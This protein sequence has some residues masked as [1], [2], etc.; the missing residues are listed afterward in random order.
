MAYGTILTV[1]SATKQLKQYNESYN[2][3]NVWNDLLSQNANSALAAE[4]ELLKSY[5]TA[6]ADAYVSY[7]KNQNAIINS[8]AVGQGRT[9]LLQ[10]NELALQDAYNSYMNSLQEGTASIQE[11][12]SQ[13]NQAVENAFAA[14]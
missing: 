2:R 11:S 13:S 3:Q 5:N 8:G 12:Y 7:L 6:T 9:N 10:D 14:R 4:N 1:D